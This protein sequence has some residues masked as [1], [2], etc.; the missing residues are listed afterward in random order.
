MTSCCPLLQPENSQFWRATSKLLR[1]LYMAGNT[2]LFAHI[3]QML[4][5]AEGV[6]P[7]YYI[8]VQPPKVPDF[9][10]RELAQRVA[11][12][13]DPDMRGQSVFYTPIAKNT[14]NWED[15]G[16][17]LGYICEFKVGVPI[18]ET[19]ESHQYFERTEI[20]DIKNK[21]WNRMW[22]E[23]CLI[24]PRDQRTLK[25]RHTLF[26]E[27]SRRFNAWLKRRDLPFEVRVYPTAPIP[28]KIR[29][30]TYYI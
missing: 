21:N 14:V 13:H 8:Q 20:A 25:D 3:L 30:M 18:N 6:R 11:S 4:M 2:D 9:I 23:R 22:S 1:E 10:S 27:R 16:P 12:H 24:D 7:G 15:M 17:E 29:D 5:V 28:R 26:N 19:T